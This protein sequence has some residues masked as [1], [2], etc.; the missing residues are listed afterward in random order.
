MLWNAAI[1]SSATQGSIAGEPNH[2]GI[3]HFTS[4]TSAN[5]GGRVTTGNTAIRLGGGEVAEFVFTCPAP[6][7]TTIRLGFIDTTSSADCV[8]GAYIEMQAG[9]ACVGKTSNNSTRTTSA[10]I[11]TLSASTWYIARIVVRKDLSGVDFYI[12]DDN[13]NL[14]GS[15]SNTTNI[16][17]GSGRETGHGIIATNSGTSAV[18]ILRLDFMSLEFTRALV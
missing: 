18:E 7:N 8:D 6:T 16:P 4:S 12:F 13:G 1:I 11:A 15:Q 17:T 9:G 14:L 3:M 2:P 5:S 10:T